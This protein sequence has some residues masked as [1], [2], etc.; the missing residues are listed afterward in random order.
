[1]KAL[2]LSLLLAL[3]VSACSSQPTV[4]TQQTNRVEVAAEEVGR[5]DTEPVRRYA[6]VDLRR[7]QDR[8]AQARQALSAGDGELAEH[9]AYLAQ[10][11]AEIGRVH[12]DTAAANARA[13]ELADTRDR[14]QNRARDAVVTLQ[15][16]QIE[17]L[18]QQ[19][20]ELNPRQT[21]RGITLTLSNVLFRFDSAELTDAAQQPLDRLAAFLR[22]YPDQGVSIEG[23][24]D[25]IGPADY[26]RELSRQRA[27]SVAD[28]MAARG[29]DRLRMTVTGYGETKPIASNETQAGRRQNRRVEFVIW[30]E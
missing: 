4:T 12:A 9:L 3:V 26:N 29:I 8:L 23:H 10:R 5:S 22:Q 28:A 14:L 21:E 11:H 15:Q 25:S 19:L 30:S 20:E 24:T 27:Q 7:A 6:P 2:A 16:R 13:D 1:M 18:R 17:R